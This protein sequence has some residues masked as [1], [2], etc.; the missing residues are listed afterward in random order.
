MPEGIERHRAILQLLDAAGPR[1]ASF[2]AIWRTRKL[3]PDV[4]IL[5]LTTDNGN[6]GIQ[7]ATVGPTNV[8]RS[9]NQG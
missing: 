3:R 1:R 4:S 2:F 6:R 7:A 8:C 9:A 5:Y